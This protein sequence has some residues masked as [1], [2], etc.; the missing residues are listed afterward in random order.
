[1]CDAPA[2]RG[3]WQSQFGAGSFCQPRKRAPQGPFFEA[4]ALSRLR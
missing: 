3:Y 1:M 4:T 2:G